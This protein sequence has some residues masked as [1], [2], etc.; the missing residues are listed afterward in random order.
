M[1]LIHVLLC[2]KALAGAPG[3]KGRGLGTV[4][5]EHL[6]AYRSAACKVFCNQWMMSYALLRKT[7]A[8]CLQPENRKPLGKGFVWICL[9]LAARVQITVE[10]PFTYH[11]NS[12]PL[13]EHCTTCT[14]T[15]P[16]HAQGFDCARLRAL[17]KKM[18]ATPRSQGGRITAGVLIR[19]CQSSSAAPVSSSSFGP[20]P[21][22]WS[23]RGKR[24]QAEWQRYCRQ[25]S[26]I[27]EHQQQGGT[28]SQ[29]QNQQHSNGDTPNKHQH[30]RL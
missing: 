19:G 8:I 6:S 12:M 26:C 9:V 5:I 15:A 1:Y 2:L 28:T 24:H 21:A 14:P 7:Q 13:L 29:H 10:N 4:V 16:L 11:F 23:S 25:T 22:V 30:Q 18:A 17:Q 3:K 20:P 27:E